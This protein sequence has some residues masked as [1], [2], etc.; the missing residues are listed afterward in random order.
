MM[1]VVDTSV[2]MIV[3]VCTKAP[4][5]SVIMNIGQH[6]QCCDRANASQQRS[7]FGPPCCGGADVD[8]SSTWITLKL[9][10]HNL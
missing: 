9:L 3:P 1:V 6:A 8:A 5:A 10:L 7:K 4:A 2:R